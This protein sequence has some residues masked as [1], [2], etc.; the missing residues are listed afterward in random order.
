MSRLRIFDENDPA[1]AL[2]SSTS[3]T[4]EASWSSMPKSRSPRPLQVN[5]SAP[6]Q[7]A[8]VFCRAADKRASRSSSARRGTGSSSVAHNTA[9][10]M[11][12]RIGANTVIVDYD[13]PFGTA[14]LDF[15][16]DPLSG[17]ADALGR[18]DRGGRG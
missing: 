16:Q 11:S 6:R 15:N 10:A 4:T 3:D 8:A 9:Y 17:V 12:E 13:L 18:M 1:T 5:N 14:G 2:V 7:F